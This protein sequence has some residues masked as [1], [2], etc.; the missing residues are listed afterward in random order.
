MFV[1]ACVSAVESFKAVTVIYDVADEE[2]F[3][4]A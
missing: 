3:E 4:S 1:D 2:K